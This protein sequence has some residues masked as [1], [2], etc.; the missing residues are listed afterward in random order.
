MLGVTAA[1]LS[2]LSTQPVD[3]QRS[4]LRDRFEYVLRV[5]PSLVYT[6]IPNLLPTRAAQLYRELLQELRAE[7][8]IAA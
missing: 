4:F 7:W 1:F 2:F 5:Y 6:T 8:S 3:V